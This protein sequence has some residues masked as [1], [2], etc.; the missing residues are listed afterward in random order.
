MPEVAGSSSLLF[1]PLSVQEMAGAIG[2]LA[3]LPQLRQYLIDKG[4]KNATRFSW[5]QT[6]E[7][8]LGVYREVLNVPAGIRMA[9]LKRAA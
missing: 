9:P 4:R 3:T 2:A 1:D 8:T 5:R 6:A 7:Q